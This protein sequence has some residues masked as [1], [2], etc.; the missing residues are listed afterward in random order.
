[1]ASGRGMK[2]YHIAIASDDVLKTQQFYINYFGFRKGFEDGPDGFIVNDDGFVIVIDKII[3]EVSFPQ[4]FHYGFMLESPQEVTRL[5]DRM[6]NDGVAFSEE[7]SQQENLAGKITTLFFCLDPN[8][9][10]IEVRC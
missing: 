3:Q 9:Y 5:Y 2:L 10:K 6:K 7:L 1:M 8:G 4:W